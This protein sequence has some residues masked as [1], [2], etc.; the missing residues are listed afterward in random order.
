MTD[1]TRKDL[2]SW[3]GDDDNEAPRGEAYLAD[4]PPVARK[5]PDEPGE[6]ELT[7]TSPSGGFEVRVTED[8]N[9]PP[10]AEQMERT[11]EA[12]EHADLFKRE[13]RSG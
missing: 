12:A 9:E 8:H 2:R 1:S 11:E 13:R 3:V 10:I 7:R 6:G 5:E 4:L